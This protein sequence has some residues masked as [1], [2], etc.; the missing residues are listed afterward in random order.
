MKHAAALRISI[1]AAMGV[2]PL[3]CGDDADN[4][5][6]MPTAG[7]GGSDTTHAG[8]TSAGDAP[9]TT[10]GRGG[11]ASSAGA[12]GA[13][14]SAGAAG[15]RTTGGAGPTITLGCT[16]TEVLPD[17]GIVYCK[18][19]GYYTRPQAVACSDTGEG[20]AGGGAADLPR[21]DLDTECTDDA[22]CAEV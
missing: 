5:S 22:D 13:A 19:Q 20:G 6:D 16:N 3:A 12:G 10:A 17:S 8:S 2:V 1:L 9:T 4:G 18:D 7:S 21:A 11:T 15:G 14:G